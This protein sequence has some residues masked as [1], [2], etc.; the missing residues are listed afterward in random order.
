MSDLAPRRV[1]GRLRRGRVGAVVLATA[2]AVAVAGCASV[3]DGGTPQLVRDRQL[4]TG[5]PRNKEVTTSLPQPG[6]NAEQTGQAYLNASRFTQD[7]KRLGE[8]FVARPARERF[9]QTTHVQIVRSLQVRP[10]RADDSATS[11]EFSGDL[12]GTVDGKSRAFVPR[13]ARRWAASVPMVRSRDV[14]LFA[15]PPPVVVAANE[16]DTAFTPVTLYFAGPRAEAGTEVVVPEDRYLDSVTGIETK[17]VDLLLAGPSSRLAG[18]ARNPLPAGTKRNSLTFIDSNS[19][20]LVLDLS[21]EAESAEADA[22]NAFVAQVGWSLRD[23]IRGRVRLQVTGRLLTV[24]GV[25]AVQG[26][27]Q[28]GRY[29][30]AARTPNQ[31][32]Y[33]ERGAVRKLDADFS[34]ENESAPFPSN[35]HLTRGVITA[36]LSTDLSA[37]AVVKNT[38]AGGQQL[39]IGPSRGPLRAS[40]VG[41]VVGRPSW[42]SGVSQV[43]VPVDGRLVQVS[44]A[45]PGTAVTVGGAPRPVRAVKVA[46]DGLRV[47]LVVG[48]GNAARVVLGSLP[49]PQAGRPAPVL[50][51]VLPLAVT[52]SPRD[53][54]W[55]GATSVAVAVQT[56]DDQSGVVLAPVDGAPAEFRPGPAVRIGP[57]RLRIAASPTQQG[58]TQIL[59]EAA[60][61]LYRV[62]SS[63]AV[64]E[65]GTSGGTA[66][67]FPG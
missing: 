34:R 42:G 66:P 33:V 54:A 44:A 61:Q 18:V 5:D 50:Q 9:V 3:P 57:G 10:R 24:P 36:A 29:N 65:S 23:Q 20:D 19:G 26:E 32:F 35:P 14:W 31:D 43:L 22:I 16:F 38:P 47:A 56:S 55:A 46:P 60:G 63:Q 52:G 25:A 12:V 15:E 37:V 59:L 21:P 48:N 4:S 51:A 17:V 53:V 8:V 49:S 58:S 39:W 64:P 27:E 2:A 1:V 6:A 45:R 13:S 41:Q 67:F 30:P 11:L 62:F 7:T 28:W 40:V